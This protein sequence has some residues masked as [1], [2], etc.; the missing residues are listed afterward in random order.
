MSGKPRQ[1][2]KIP[3]VRTER[4]PMAV[5]ADINEAWVTLE[6]L[7]QELGRAMSEA[8]R[9]RAIPQREVAA[10]LGLSRDMVAL[11]ELGKRWKHDSS[12]IERLAF[13]LSK[14][15]ICNIWA[16]SPEQ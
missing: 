14:E 15:D 3:T 2:I 10:H 1:G 6:D 12:H 5:Y 16:Q 9:A 4:D 13:F 8:R 7:Y 11:Y